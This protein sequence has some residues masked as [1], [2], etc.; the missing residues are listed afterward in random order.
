MD[1]SNTDR[2]VQPNDPKVTR[3]RRLKRKNLAE[4]PVRQPSP[5]EKRLKQ[6]EDSPPLYNIKGILSERKIGKTTEFLIDWEDNPETGEPYEPTWE[7]YSNVTE[8]AIYEWESKQAINKYKSQLQH[9]SSQDSEPIPPRTRSK[10]NIPGAPGLLRRRSVRNTNEIAGERV[11]TKNKTREIRDSYENQ[12]SSSSND[13]SIVIPLNKEINPNEYTVF[14]SSQVSNYSSTQADL[15]ASSPLQVPNSLDSQSLLPRRKSAPAFIW[16]EDI[17]AGSQYLSGSTSYNPSIPRRA[18]DCEEDSPLSVHAEVSDRARKG[19][20]RSHLSPEALITQHTDT[21]DTVTVANEEEREGGF[22]NNINQ[23]APLEK[24]SIPDSFTID[25]SLSSINVNLVQSAP[26]EPLTPKPQQHLR[27]QPL[28][29]N[30]TDRTD[31]EEPSQLPPVTNISPAS[32]NSISYSKQSF[33]HSLEEKAGPSESQKQLQPQ[34]SLEIPDSYLLSDPFTKSSPAQGV[35]TQTAS[36]DRASSLPNDNPH[37]RTLLS[38][39]QRSQSLPSFTNLDS[40]PEATCQAAQ[41]I[42]QI[43]STSSQ[44]LNRENSQ[45]QG[46]LDHVQADNSEVSEFTTTHLDQYLEGHHHLSKFVSEKHCVIHSRETR[47]EIPET[48]PSASEPS[49]EAALPQVL[50]SIESGAHLQNAEL[51]SQE[52]PLS[53][54]PAGLAWSSGRN[55]PLHSSYL[56]EK[57][58]AVGSSASHLAV[59]ERTARSTKSRSPSSMPPR[60]ATAPPTGST[61]HLLPMRDSIT[62]T[63]RPRNRA[64]SMPR[65]SIESTDMSPNVLTIRKL[66]RNEFII[67]LPM[68]TQVRDVYDTTIRNKKNDIVSFLGRSSTAPDSDSMDLMI[69]EL[70]LIC[71]HQDLIVEESSTQSLDDSAQARYAVTISTKF[72]FIQQFLDSLR[73]AKVHVVILARDAILPILESLFRWQQYNYSRPDIPGNPGK[74]EKDLMEIT[75]L[76]TWIDVRDCIVSPASVVVAFDSSFS[77]SQGGDE[78][79]EIL[80]FDPRNPDKR[81]P[82][83]WLV[84]T[85]SIEHVELC[86]PATLESSERKDR[87]VQYVAQTRKFIGRLDTS[88]YPEPQQAARGAAEYVLDDSIEAEWPIMPMPNIDISLPGHGAFNRQPDS[89]TQSLFSPVEPISQSGFKRPSDFDALDDDNAIKRQRMTPSRPDS[90]TVNGNMADLKEIRSL[91]ARCE[92]YEKSIKRIQPKYQRALDEKARYEHENAQAVKRQSEYEKKLEIHDGAAAKLR[93]ENASL[94]NELAV[95][96]NSLSTSAVPSIAELQ[97]AKD[98]LRAAQAEIERLKKGQVSVE[99]RADYA[100]SLYQESSQ[101]AQEMR[102]QLTNLQSERE[103]LQK[104]A[105]AARVEIQKINNDGI[106][107]QQVDTINELK[108]ELAERERMLESLTRQLE[109]YTNGRRT[110]RGTSVPRSPRMSNMSPRPRVLGSMAPGSNTASRGNSPAPGVFGGDLFQGGDA[111]RRFGAHLQ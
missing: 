16:D 43:P 98:D 8:V 79:S 1:F 90:N 64:V 10:S 49:T 50:A 24:S 100:T 94:K 23:R 109:S 105:S 5:S 89:L 106:I 14:R 60:V 55:S 75:L 37:S 38:D 74:S 6:K 103:G 72:L 76:P 34:L 13:L 36:Q 19:I 61:N 80:P 83:L 54:G 44:D 92:D 51:Q 65:S 107:Q 9:T 77:A 56:V 31:S 46:S 57:M 71:D 26:Q 11:G 73:A 7:P 63:S 66:G 67:P 22:S 21:V 3:Q 41:I 70:K 78:Y 40:S 17:E 47:T 33:D 87:L 39:S 18:S 62:D 81:A 12:G 111:G 42:S 27:S 48:Q 32:E 53:Q 86:I 30:R 102:N 110:T 45:S 91:R 20:A 85:N 104:Q 28:R 15:Q 29:S 101:Q 69:E 2:A 52:S 59:G 96:Q 99:K 4:S 25:H 84:I 93:E 58:S 108:R 35:N 68:M 97:K 95:A 82:L 88:I